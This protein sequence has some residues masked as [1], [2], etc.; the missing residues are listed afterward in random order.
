MAG[1]GR[2]CVDVSLP[3]VVATETSNKFW[4]QMIPETCRSYEIESE[5]VPAAGA[6]DGRKSTGGVQVGEGF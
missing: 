6:G 3:E 4:E 2:G 5:S 1:S